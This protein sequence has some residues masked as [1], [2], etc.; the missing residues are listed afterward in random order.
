M[1]SSL[2]REDCRLGNGLRERAQELSKRQERGKRIE[3]EF[4]EQLDRYYASPT[5]SFYLEDLEREFYEQK[6][7]HLGFTPYPKDGY[8]TFGASQTSKC[9]R[10]IFYKYGDVKPEKSDDLPFRGR[11]RRIGTAVVD[12]LQ[13]DLIH[14]PERLGDD[15]K[16]RVK[17]TKSG[18]FA[19]ED[20]AAHRRVFEVTLEDG[21]SC[22]FAIF[23]KPDGILEYEGSNLLFE[24]KTKA[25]GIKPMNQ[26]LDYKGA[27]EDHLRQVTAESLVFG[28]NEG[29]ILYESTQKPAW[30][31]DEESKS[32]TKGNKTWKDGQP[33]PDM[34]AFY[35]RITRKMQEDLLIDLA[36]QARKVYEGEKPEVTPEMTRK[37]GFCA[38]W[39]HCHNDLTAENIEKLREADV[40]YESS[41]YAGSQNHKMLRAY[42][43]AVPDGR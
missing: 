38:F 29:I 9:D 28:I 12:Y 17:R 15:C 27:Q 3:Q 14:M 19:F 6:I 4:M 1:G 13:L 24:Y 21:Y 36:R 39:E 26:K 37:C 41:K 34:R 30:F 42:L 20:A 11:Q 18:E 32:V 43:E 10:E 31:S 23:A 2:K 7:R 25:T 40:R 8:I 22:R 35:F 5:A 16:F 33:V